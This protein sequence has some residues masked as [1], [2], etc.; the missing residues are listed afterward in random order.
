MNKTLFIFTALFLFQVQLLQ[1]QIAFASS[2]EH[3][4]AM[5]SVDDTLFLGTNL[6][7]VYALITEGQSNVLQLKLLS[8]TTHIE[9]RDIEKLSNN[10]LI[11][12]QTGEESS[13]NQLYSDGRS[14]FKDPINQNSSIF[15]DGFSFD[16]KVGFLMGDPIDD[17]FS[18]FISEDFG[19]SWKKLNALKSHKGE[20]AFAASGSTV[21]NKSNK[22]I[23]VSGG[24]KARF[25]ISKNKGQ[26]W[27]DFDLPIELCESCGINSMLVVNRIFFKKRIILVGG[28]FRKPNKRE[29][30][31]IYSDNWGRTWKKS[32]V[33]PT[34][35]RSKIVFNQN[36]QT[37]YTGGI[38]GI[39]ISKDFGKTWKN[40]NGYSCYNMEFLNKILVVSSKSGFIHLIERRN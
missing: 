30:V 26:S 23:F 6:G 39:D 19:G 18:L 25:F 12:M 20:A 33:Q 9:I 1:S 22:F 16:G 8:E 28:D 35:Y 38:N 32:K 29:D 36:N 15:L 27:K 37:L 14:I 11:Y 3:A 34:G 2:N 7:N 4:R 17:N 13:M 24:K 40:L 5:C 10:E 31:C 21:Y